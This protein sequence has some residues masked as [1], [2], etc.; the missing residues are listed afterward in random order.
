MAPDAIVIKGN[1]VSLETDSI[2]SRRCA[3]R[4]GM[5]RH[6][7]SF[8][9]LLDEDAT[10]QTTA[11]RNG[12]SLT[13]H[14]RRVQICSGNGFSLATVLGDGSVVL[15]GKRGAVGDSSHSRVVQN[16][17]KN[18][19]QLQAND[20]KNMR[21]GFV[22]TWGRP[23]CGGDGRAV[24][25]PAIERATDPSP[26]LVVCISDCFTSTRKVLMILS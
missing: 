17:L 16:K 14:V 8:R 19:P 24:K 18:V 2:Q 4:V 1:K 5:G 9:I 20:G 26:A 21:D 6:L 25:D 7:Q 15:W 13:W 12:G 11:L 3:H 22:T 23:H 10:L